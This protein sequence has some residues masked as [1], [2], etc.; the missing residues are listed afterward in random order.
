MKRRVLFFF[1]LMA[2]YSISQAQLG[3]NG[4][5]GAQ[6]LAM[7]GAGST[8]TGS[9]ALFNNQAG[10]LGVDDLAVVLDVQRRFSLADLSVVSAG[11]V[12]NSKLGAF[13]LMV[14]SYGFEAYKDQKIGLAYAKKLTDILDI[15]GQLNVLQIQIDN[16]GS[17]TNLSFELGAI[18]ELTEELKLGFHV[19]NPLSVAITENTELDSRFRLGLNYTPS[20][21][22]QLV[23]EADKILDDTALNFRV[24]IQY[25]LLPSLQIRTGYSTSPGTVSFGLGYR[26]NDTLLFDAAYSYH[27]QLGYTP[28]ISV[29]WNKK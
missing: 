26:F 3:L 10:I 16:F 18:A 21:K 8:L 4:S 27:E 23:A 7:G 12:K 28:G 14:S 19:N 5:D 15:G 22:V 17:S 20:S 11:V 13:G 24:G 29:I 1:L 2:S 6:G 9:Y 25:A